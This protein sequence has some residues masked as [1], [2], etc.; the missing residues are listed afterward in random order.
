[1]G[2]LHNPGAGVGHQGTLDELPDDHR[3]TCTGWHGADWVSSFLG[4]VLE[5]AG[6]SRFLVVS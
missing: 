3:L 5:D 4:E 1:M 2:Q 6:N